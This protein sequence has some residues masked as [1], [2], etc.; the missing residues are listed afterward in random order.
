MRE[1]DTTL[2]IASRC[3]L[4]PHTAVLAHLLARVLSATLT[5]VCQPTEII[6]ISVGQVSLKDG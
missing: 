2:S 3:S 1:I 6:S 5:A 4:C